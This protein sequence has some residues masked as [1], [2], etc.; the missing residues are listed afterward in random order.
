MCPET[1]VRSDYLTLATLVE[2]IPTVSA[3]FHLL[4]SPRPRH[5]PSRGHIAVRVLKVGT[6]RGHYLIRDGNYTTVTP[7]P[8]QR[9]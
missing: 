1:K 4:G 5:I 3:S 8:S 6:M 7:K 9:Q 2:Y